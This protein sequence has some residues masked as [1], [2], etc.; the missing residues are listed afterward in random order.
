MYG[1]LHC[2]LNFGENNIVDLEI[3]NLPNSP[4]GIEKSCG[5]I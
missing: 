1:V 5:S 3:C 2:H 4:V